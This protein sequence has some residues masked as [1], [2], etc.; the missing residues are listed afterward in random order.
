MGWVVPRLTGGLELQEVMKPTEEQKAIVHAAGRV[1]RINAR[2]GTGKTTTL[3]MLAREH[4]DK[5]ILYLVFNRKARDEA[6]SKFPENVKV[7]TIHSLAWGAVGKDFETIGD[8]GPKDLLPYFKASGNAQVLSKIARDFLAFFLNSPFER[9]EDAVDGFEKLL[10]EQVKESFRHHLPRVIDGV[11][12]LA[13]QWNR[14]DR[15]CPHDFYLKMFHK[16][17]KFDD[18]LS[19]YDMVLVDE[20]QDLSGVMLDALKKCRKRVVIVG[21]SHQQIYRFR[22]ALDAMRNLV[23]DEDYEL[24]L[25]FRFGKTIANLASH[26]IR[27][28]KCENKFKIVGNPHKTSDLLVSEFSPRKN[29]AILSRT[30]LALF[31]NAMVLRAKKASFRFERDIEKVLWQTLDVYWLAEGDKSKIRSEWIQSFDDFKAL[32]EYAEDCSDFQL[33][34]VS[35]VV[36]KYSA[37]FPD[38]IFDMVGVNK[39]KAENGDSNAAILS[40]IHAAKGQEYENVYIDSDVADMLDSAE[41]MEQAQYDEEVNIAYVGFTR[42]IKQ[43]SISNSFQRILTPIWQSFLKG[44][45]SPSR[46]PERVRGNAFPYSARAHSPKSREF[47]PGKKSKFLFQT[48]KRAKTPRPGPKVGDRVDT[49]HGVGLVVETDNGKYLVKLENQVASIWERPSSIKPCADVE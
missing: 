20:A 33:R 23:C 48:E 25:S 24:T 42:A 7:K 21:D 13:T 12:N 43:L 31:S 35:Q 29:S 27:E 18:A 45:R 4:A 22:Y 36:R 28:A 30:N 9:I 41:K 37:S 2:A 3:H 19:R 10:P 26:L 49:P 1:I 8:F 6:Q 38:V 34:G 16:S 15:P 32:E 47:P 17:G 11:R 40:T 14:K 44:H 39:H 46:P 5:K